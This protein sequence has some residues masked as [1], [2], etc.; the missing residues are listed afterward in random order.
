MKCLKDYKR[1]SALY[2]KGEEYNID[3]ETIKEHET[4]FGEKLWEGKTA[5]KETKKRVSKS[6]GKK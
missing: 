5:K 2:L 3:K 4:Y 6:K 1:H